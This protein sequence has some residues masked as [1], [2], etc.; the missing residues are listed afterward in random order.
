MIMRCVLIW[1]LLCAPLFAEP[2][3][4][5]KNG[6]T[7]IV[8]SGATTVPLTSGDL[9]A[10]TDFGQLVANNAAIQAMRKAT[11]MVD[12][13]A[14]IDDDTIV[15]GYALFDGCLIQT[16][17]RTTSH[18]AGDGSGGLYVYHSNDY[19]DNED[20][21][22]IIDVG[23]GADDYIE[24]VDQSV[25]NVMQFGA[26]GNY[27]STSSTGTDDAAAIQACFDA[28]A[29]RS[30][31]LSATWPRR[32]KAVIPPNK[33]RC[34]TPLTLSGW[35]DLDMSG[36]ELYFPSADPSEGPLLTIGDTAHRLKGKYLGLAVSAP[37]YASL[38]Q[39]FPLA[40][41]DSYAAI[42]IRNMSNSYFQTV[43]CEGTSIGLQLQPSAALPVALNT[44]DLGY[45]VSCKVAVDVRGNTST[46][47]VNQNYYRAGNITP[48]GGMSPFGN[49]YG[50]RFSTP[51]GGYTSNNNNVFVETCFQM[52][53]KS[54]T[55]DWSSGKPGL[56][57][58]YYYFAPT[59]KTSWQVTSVGENQ[60]AGTD[61]PNG[62]TVFTDNNGVE[63]TPENS[64]YSVD[65]YERVPILHE[66]CGI[67]N[68]FIGCRYES[69]YGAPVVSR[70]T[71][72][73]PGGKNKYDFAYIF[74]ID[75]NFTNHGYI[76][77]VGHILGQGSSVYAFATKL[78]LDSIATYNGV[79]HQQNR[80]LSALQDRAIQSS[81]NQVCVQGMCFFNGTTKAIVQYGSSG[82]M[83]LCTDGIRCGTTERLGVLMKAH[84]GMRF[85]VRKLGDESGAGQRG[86]IYAYD[87][88]FQPLAINNT[89]Y[90]VFADSMYIDAGGTYL[91]DAG[92]LRGTTVQVGYGKSPDY[93]ALIT[94]EQTG[95]KQPGYSIATHIHPT[96][97][98]D[99]AFVT[100]F[101]SD[102]G[103]RFSYGTPA[104]GIFKKAGEWI[105][106]INTTA[107]QPY[108]WNVTTPGYLA[109]A[110]ASSATVLKNE[111][112][113]AGGNAYVAQM[114]GTTGATTPTG[115]GADIDDD[116]ILW[117][118][119]GPE[120][121]ITASASTY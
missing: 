11:I 98:T 7:V 114:A 119:L 88:A 97:E 95:K 43:L 30:I 35:V 33:Y 31:E 4:G 52:L 93:I 46:G 58:G 17:R 32:A 62:T 24:L 12:T 91:Q 106:N 96:L 18:T 34:D 41:K 21:G 84:E 16:K 65:T 110:W 6:S 118:Y 68:T 90:S 112:R 105:A 64:T 3:V 50:V 111:I 99:M 38:G 115:T 116:T 79:R 28:A 1:L 5:T 80:T 121:A 27:V 113:T 56:K 81:T 87:R 57:E 86:Y 108:G 54:T 48:G 9:G 101:G 36:A 100:P 72:L 19:A 55:Y 107:A 10:W 75:T 61:E 37:N 23:P 20:G 76:N 73:G 59:T 120:A 29:A 40:Y 94:L 109:A 117:D 42:R 71:T 63:W 25:A 39:R 104:R 60:T 92:V 51:S 67:N 69:G 53:T 103:G 45:F 2:Q 26:V 14:D 49:T 22:F 77:D 70:A 85:D 66:N 13:V 44:F 82:N 102:M 15:P 89:D 47:Y 83:V 74:S 8:D 78:S